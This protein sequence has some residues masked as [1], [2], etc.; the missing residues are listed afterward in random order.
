[1]PRITS[2][3]MHCFLFVFI[4]VDKTGLDG[5]IYVM[6]KYKQFQKRLVLMVTSR[7]RGRTGIFGKC[8]LHVMTCWKEMVDETDNQCH[9]KYFWQSTR[10][11]KSALFNSSKACLL[12]GKEQGNI[13]LKLCACFFSTTC[14]VTRVCCVAWFYRNVICCVLL[15]AAT[16]Y[17]PALEHQKGS[18]S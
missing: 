4:I 10:R 13:Q 3:G 12:I 6:K 17:L 8:V 15:Y 9:F 11:R 7:L 18:I 5:N 1:V 14:I 16:A 2:H